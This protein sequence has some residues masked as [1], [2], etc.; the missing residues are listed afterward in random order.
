MVDTK[1]INFG[2][3]IHRAPCTNAKP[4]VSWW[5]KSAAGNH[6]DAD[7]SQWRKSAWTS[8]TFY[9][10]CMH[11]DLIR[12]VYK[13][14]LCGWHPCYV[15]DHLTQCAWGETS[16]GICVGYDSWVSAMP[17]AASTWSIRKTEAH[18]NVCIA[19]RIAQ[20]CWQLHANYWTVLVWEYM[21]DHSIGVHYLEAF[22]R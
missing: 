14:Y 15:S 18:C 3:D 16:H 13:V 5:D 2:G 21:P 20:C 7:G 4:N 22:C 6:P 10:L 9:R 11:A 1:L 19:M 12:V 8:R 17:I